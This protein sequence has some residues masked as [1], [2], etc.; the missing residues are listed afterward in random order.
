MAKRLEVARYWGKFLLF[1][2]PFLLKVR[3]YGGNPYVEARGKDHR[4]LLPKTTPIIGLPI[5]GQNEDLIL[6]SR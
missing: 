3:L 4:D 1:E 5:S 2:D 6:D